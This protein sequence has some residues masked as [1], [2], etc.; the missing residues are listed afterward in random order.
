LGRSG[1][2]YE[3]RPL[4]SLYVA[5]RTIRIHLK[6]SQSISKSLQGAVKDPDGI[7]FLRVQPHLRLATGSRDA[8]TLLTAHRL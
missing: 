5:T 8:N 7:L 3:K 2:G 1:C 4:K 6:A